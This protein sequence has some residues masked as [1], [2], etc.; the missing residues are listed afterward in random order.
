MNELIIGTILLSIFVLQGVLCSLF[1]TVF[2][3]WKAHRAREHE[4]RALSEK[5]MA[6]RRRVVQ[7]KSG[8]EA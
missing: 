3:K 8:K 4:Y 7:A 5:G 1:E 6:Y 2:K